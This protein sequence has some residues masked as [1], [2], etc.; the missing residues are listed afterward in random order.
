M[1]VSHELKFVIAAPV[2]LGAGP[3]LERIREEGDEGW[4]EIVGHANSV[5][6]PEGCESYARYFID[7]P[8]HRLPQ[9][10]LDRLGTPWEGPRVNMSVEDW[11]KW[12]LW[13]MRK[14][15]MEAGVFA[16]PNGWGMRGVDGEWMFFDP[17]SILHRTLMGVGISP[18]GEVAPWGRGEA[19]VLRMQ[20]Y[21]RGWRELHKRIRTAGPWRP[22]KVSREA[23]N[24]MDLLRWHIPVMQHFYELPDEL[25][26]AYLSENAWEGGKN[27]VE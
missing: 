11:L 19:R 2:G 14:M 9:M 4:L 6:V 15:I 27:G 16:S 22:G 1:I 21:S 8:H 13:G 20:E 24:T 25:V 17:P 12:Y 26:S 3:W 23:Q 10:W 5:C 18:L 7:A